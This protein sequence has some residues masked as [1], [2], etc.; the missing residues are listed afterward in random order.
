VRAGPDRH[1]TPTA[2]LRPEPA[3]RRC[4]RT[5]PR[6][7][8]N[9]SAPFSER[10]SHWPGRRLP[11]RA[12]IGGG[13]AVGERRQKA[14]PRRVAAARV[15]PRASSPPVRPGPARPGPV[16]SGQVR[17]G[18]GGP[19]A[20][21]PRGPSPGIPHSGRPASL[22]GSSALPLPASVPA[23]PRVEPLGTGAWQAPA[24][25]PAPPLGAERGSGRARGRVCVCR[26]QTPRRSCSWKWGLT[27]RKFL[28]KKL[29][30]ISVSLLIF[31]L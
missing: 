26:G 21:V 18:H 30:I 24:A 25:P 27:G 23:G 3:G 19:R 4:G 22:W 12:G 9:S 29:S 5:S 16:R 31:C 17:S 10:R 13:G 7:P 6:R 2:P 20:P 1:H 28:E 8:A 14:K 15:S 11:P